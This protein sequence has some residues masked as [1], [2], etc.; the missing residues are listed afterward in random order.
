MR[1]QLRLV[2][3]A[4]VVVLALLAG[5]AAPAI[6]DQGSGGSGSGATGDKQPIFDFSDVFY[7]AN[8]ID[9]A[10]LAGRHTGADGVSVI[11]TAP[12]ANHRNVRVTL[13]LPAYDTS[14]GMHYFT[15]LEDLA[16]T[17]FLNN[18]AG[19]NAKRIAD[20]NTVWVFPTRTGNQTAVSNNRQADMVDLSGGYFSN[21][22]LGLWVHVFVSW[23]NKIDTPAGKGRLADLA[24][25]N[26]LAL[27]GTPIIKSKSDIESLAKDG[28]VTLIKRG[29][30]ETGRYFVCPVYKDPTHGAIAP[31]AFLAT[32]RR[33]D[34]SPLP[35]EQGF[36]TQFQ[37]LQTTGR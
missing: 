27:D 35:A 16:P 20:A 26:G 28:Y 23:T 7:R 36:V 14:G 25:K 10:G 4:L 22:P 18:S 15:V 24:R 31:D 1:H 12:D 19:A 3:R 6:A 8:G 2:I 29:T 21:D 34:G 37:S 33:A 9:P 5:T 17:A 13:V 11:S 32:V 30:T